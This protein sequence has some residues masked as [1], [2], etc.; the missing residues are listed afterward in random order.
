MTAALVLLLAGLPARVDVKTDTATF[1]AAYD[2]ALDEGK[3]HWR[4][5]GTTE[6]RLLPP[7]GLPAPRGRLEALKEL[8]P[9]D[10]TPF[11]RPTRIAR[12]SADG[13]NLLAVTPEG[14]AYYTKLSTLDWT[15][16][17]GPVG[18]K[19]P[20]VVDASAQAFAMS[21][22]KI[23]YE[24]LDGNPHPVTAGVTTVYALFDE[25]KRLAYADPWL[26]PG[27]GRA[28]CLPERNTFV[29][30]ALSASASTLFVMDGSGRAFTRLADFDTLGDDPAL[31]YS[32]KRERRRGAASVIRT[33]PAEPW[34]AQPRIEATH[35]ARI[36][37][38][39]TGTHNRDRE[40]RV[41]G[42]GG[43]WKK[44]LS[45]GRWTFERT[46][47]PMQGQRV[48]PGLHLQPLRAA[49]WV[50]E[51]TFE[52]AALRLEDFD[53][54]CSPARFVLDR[55]AE[56]LT[57]DLHFHGSLVPGKRSGA[58][59]LPKGRLPLLAK[60]RA[61][62]LGQD[63]L[64]VDVEVSPDAVVVKKAPLVEWRFRRRM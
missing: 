9:I 2:I 49:T 63:F 19:G 14:R 48:V 42:E 57:V 55:G 10:P 13:D 28:I 17:W 47:E 31:P 22:R 5:R 52:G 44:P 25:G 30:S 36:T 43:F 6:W 58:L 50:G 16:T 51:G 35:S 32:W 39:Q 7:D 41:E 46:G 34:F 64:E 4:K 1:S 45:T 53:P 61:L 12:V 29:A 18:L 26:P 20:L 8:L 15:D 59:L 38:V 24:D 33:L 11:T 21:H 27:F 3:L 40:L 56:R 37:I 60:L 23:P 54:D 62:A